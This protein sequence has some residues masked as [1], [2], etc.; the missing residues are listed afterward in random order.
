MA[1]AQPQETSTPTPD[2]ASLTGGGDKSAI[3]DLVTMQK[4][5]TA[6]DFSITRAADAKL[7][8]D[9]TRVEK[10]YTAEGVGH[11]ELKPWDANKEHA[12]FEHDPIEGFGSVGGLFAM[13]ASAFTK[14][15]MDNAI[16]GMAGALNSIKAGDEAAYERA[17]GSWKD[18]TK[19]ALDRHK[20]QHD[21][22]GDALSLMSANQGAAQAK[23]HNAAVRFGDSQ[24]LTLIE[25]GLSKELFE[26]T[27]ARNKSITSAYDLMGKITERS[28]QD[29]AVN[30][31]KKGFQSTG[32][33]VADKMHLAAQ[34][35]QIYSGGKPVGNP[36]QEAVGVYVNKHSPNEPDYIDGLAEIYQKFSPRA[37]NIEGYQQARQ[38]IVDKEGAI[39]PEKDAELLRNFGL[40]PKTGGGATSQFDPGN[41]KNASQLKIAQL[42]EIQAESEKDGKTLS[43]NEAEAEW[44]KRQTQPSLAPDEIKKFGEQ[45]AMGDTSVLTNIGRGAQ[46]AANVLAVRKAAYDV[47]ESRGQKPADLAMLNARYQGLKAAER[48]SA[49]QEMKMGAAAWEAS[50]QADLALK[51]S[52]KL[53]RSRIVPFNAMV[54]KYEEKTSD[55]DMNSFASANNT[56]VNSYVRAISPTGISTDLVRKHAYD[57]LNTALSN[58]A[59]RRVVD[60]LKQEMRLAVVSPGQMLKQMEAEYKHNAN[61]EEPPAP[62]MTPTANPMTDTAK[63]IKYDKEGNRIP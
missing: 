39:A 50:N 16:N 53:P 6:E 11:D 34:V 48:A 46:S 26:L 36:L 13:V 25:H 62:G 45:L 30:A 21:L 8:S 56:F 23:L 57:M 51:L 29:A 4:A 31:V 15:P 63:T 32:D 10:A 40:S 22:Y 20:V 60:V 5:R 54:Q 41:P 42:K 2:I 17:Y 3:S 38:A 19:L 12:K 37:S 18:N 14:T 59:Y 49:T 47:M 43:L 35:H 52:D 33:E 27:D 9:Q 7:S 28:F 61:P 58:E 55:P 1:E 44:K 24:M